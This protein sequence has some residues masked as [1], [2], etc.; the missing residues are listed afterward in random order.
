MEL[1]SLDPG[2]VQ[3][4]VLPFVT[5]GAMLILKAQVCP[6]GDAGEPDIAPG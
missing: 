1:L 6:W 3:G 4:T 5:D 2:S